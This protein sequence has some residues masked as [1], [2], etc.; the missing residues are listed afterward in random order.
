VE[1]GRRQ[2]GVV[3]RWQLLDAGVSSAAIGRMLRAGWLTRLHAGVYL[4]ASHLLTQPT[5]WMAAVLAGGAGA[6]LSHVSAGAHWEIID[7]IGG[8]T[9][10]TA[11]GGG[12]HRLGIVFH[13]AV[14][15]DPFRTVHKRIP[16]TNPSRTVL[17]L[18]AVLSPNRL[19]RAVETAD[20]LGLLDLTQ[21]TRLCESSPG[22]KGTAPLR[23][24][25]AKYHPLPETRSELERRFLRLCRDS[26]LPQPAVNVPLAG[27]EVDFL[28]AEPRIVVELDGYAFHGDRASFE[29]DRR[30]D[31]ML[32]TAGYRVV[33]ITHRRLA[34]EAASVVAELQVLLELR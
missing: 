23:L 21:L 14:D 8:P 2:H 32:Q 24:L 27:L 4:I 15:L 11:S 18:A 33:R 20:R 34:Q 13:R 17:D 1:L 16:V 29:R 10:V 28:W 22:R 30:R 9:H 19:E 12:R 3:A 6:V 26:G 7:P 5:R 25:L 31:A